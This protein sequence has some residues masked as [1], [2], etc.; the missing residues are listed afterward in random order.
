MMKGAAYPFWSDAFP[1]PLGR[2][3]PSH[4]KGV[5]SKSLQG[6][7]LSMLMSKFDHVQDMLRVQTEEVWSFDRPMLQLTNSSGQLE[8][9]RGLA[10]RTHGQAP[11]NAGACMGRYRLLSCCRSSWC[12]VATSQSEA[13]T[14]AKLSS[15]VEGGFVVAGA[16]AQKKVAGIARS[17]VV[18]QPFCNIFCKTFPGFVLSISSHW[19]LG[20]LRFCSS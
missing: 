1:Q 11:S 15:N 12:K 16:A 5:C 7:F 10:K 20:W 6:L 2:L 19:G 13:S 4:H 17:L 18:V 8:P 9:A 3:F 14:L